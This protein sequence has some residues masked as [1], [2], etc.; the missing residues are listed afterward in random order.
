MPE[1]DPSTYTWLTY[2]WV[3]LLSAWGGL[4][5]F[6]KKVRTGETRASNLMEF[7]GELV[8]SAFAGVIT[9]FLC[10]ASGITPLMTAVLVAISGHMG[11]RAIFL[12]ERWFE[13]HVRDHN[14][15]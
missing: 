2:M 15:P 5:S 14:H 3:F 1:K 11:T 8:T 10:E 9:F 4:V 13:K 7:I 6:I 12:F